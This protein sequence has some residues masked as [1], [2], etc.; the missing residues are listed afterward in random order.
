[1]VGKG[2]TSL[3]D[4]RDV[5][6]VVRSDSRIRVIALDGAI[7]ERAMSLPPPLEMHDAQIVATALV[8]RDSGANVHL[9]TQDQTIMASGLIA[10]VW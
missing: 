7:I 1:M 2:R 4:W 9:L 6:R 10:I 8:E 5:I 3:R